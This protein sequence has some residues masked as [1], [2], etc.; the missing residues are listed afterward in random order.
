[1]AADHRRVALVSARSASAGSVSDDGHRADPA[2]TGGID[3]GNPQR[4]GALEERVVP[5]AL[6]PRDL[7]GAALEHAAS[8]RSTASAMEIGELS[9]PFAESNDGSPRLD[10]RAD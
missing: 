8:R 5:G 7:A 3:R 2:Q 9:G 10:G 4:L 6:V 1:M